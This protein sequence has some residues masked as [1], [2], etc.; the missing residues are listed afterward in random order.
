MQL[1]AQPSRAKLG[2][3]AAGAVEAILALGRLG[4]D[5]DS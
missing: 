2:G 3:D 5:L 1:R 4:V